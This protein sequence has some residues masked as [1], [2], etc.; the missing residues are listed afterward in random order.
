MTSTDN[1]VKHLSCASH[2][3]LQR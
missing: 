1:E 2:E 3:D